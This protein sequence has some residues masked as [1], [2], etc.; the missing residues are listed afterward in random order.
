MAER[1]GGSFDRAVDAAL[2]DLSPDSLSEQ[3]NKYLADAHA[4]EGQAIQ[5][6]SKAPQLAGTSELA[7]AYEEVKEDARGRLGRLYDPADYPSAVRGLFGVEWD[8][9]SVE[10]PAYLMRLSP[11]LYRQEQALKG[12]R[13][14]AKQDRRARLLAFLGGI[15]SPRKRPR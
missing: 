15:V 9:P 2:A 5:L 3:L 13:A 11:D 8:F 10:P 14:R 4:I 6:L 1:L 7:S 12:Q